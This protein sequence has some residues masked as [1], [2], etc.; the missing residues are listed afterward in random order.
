MYWRDV[1]TLEA[2]QHGTDAEG[3]PTETVE[4]TQVFADVQ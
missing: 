4:A 1:I 3:Y 2:V